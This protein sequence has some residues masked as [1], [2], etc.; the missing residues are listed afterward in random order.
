MRKAIK[1]IL[2][3]L[4]M[5]AVGCGVYYGYDYY[6]HNILGD[7]SDIT[8]KHY[9]DNT[10]WYTVAESAVA[11]HP[12]I[13]EPISYNPN[14]EYEG[15]TV[16][17]YL[18]LNMDTRQYI[19]VSLPTG[20]DYIYNYSSNIVSTDGAIEVS[21]RKGTLETFT[22]DIENPITKQ[23]QISLIGEGVSLDAICKYDQNESKAPHIVYNFFDDMVL[24]ATCYSNTNDYSILVNSISNIDSLSIIGGNYECDKIVYDKPAYNEENVQT[25]FTGNAYQSDYIWYEDGYIYYINYALPQ[26]D[27]IQVCKAYLD[28]VNADGKTTEYYISDA[29]RMYESENYTIGFFRNNEQFYTVLIGYGSEAR[30]NI[31]IILSNKETVNDR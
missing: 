28:V 17:Y 3:L 31:A 10:H 19:K 5:V 8:G 26:S 6:K 12:R 18:C 21:L 7:K 29:V 13:K 14:V 25:F 27:L 2:I 20:H 9:V 24:V 11:K 1:V 15:Q 16:S 4:L 22:V 30:N 23:K